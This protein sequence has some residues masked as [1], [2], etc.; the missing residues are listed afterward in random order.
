MVVDRFLKT[1]FMKNIYT[2]VLLAFISLSLT[3]QFQKGN[4]FINGS[5]GAST[6]R[7]SN[8][9]GDLSYK[10]FSFNIGPTAGYFIQDN[11]AVGVG[12]GYSYSKNEYV[13]SSSENSSNS[14]GVS[15]FARKYFPIT[16]NL[17]LT[18][19]GY[20]NGGFSKFENQT[21]ESNGFN[22]GTYISP[23]LVFLMNPNWSLDLS[24][25]GFGYSFNR[26]T[27]TE[28]STNRVG[29]NLGSIGLGWTY[30]FRN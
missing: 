15:F 17:A 20:L 3:A 11:L 5:L 13:L 28:T 4:K 29:L 6:E 18:V 23:S 2:T 1:N 19:T 14:A 24:M 10:Y 25:G 8:S 21:Q 30:Y 27:T 22:I 7:Q 9:N 16:E 12:A 26:N